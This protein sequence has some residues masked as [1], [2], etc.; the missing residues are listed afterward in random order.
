V[1]ARRVRGDAVENGDDE[2]GLGE[3]ALATRHV[4]ARDQSG[5]GDQQGASPFESPRH[6]AELPEAAFTEQQ[7]DAAQSRVPR[8]LRLQR[9]G[10]G[11][12]ADHWVLHPCSSQSGD[13]PAGSDSTA[14]SERCL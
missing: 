9:E 5:V 11:P 14:C 12:R 7:L 6:F 13:T 2:P 8:R 10:I 4:A 3:K 1:L